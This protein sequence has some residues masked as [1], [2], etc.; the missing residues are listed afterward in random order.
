MKLS[1][2]V[3]ASSW[4]LVPRYDRLFGPSLLGS[5]SLWSPTSALLRDFGNW[6]TSMAQTSPRYEVTNTD[7]EMKLVFDVPGVIADNLDVSVDHERNVLTIS[8][9]RE[10]NENGSS[11]S[12]QFSNSFSLGPEIEVDKLNADLKDGVLTIVAPKDMKRLEANIRKIHIMSSASN[13]EPM[14]IEADKKT[15][16]QNVEVKKEAANV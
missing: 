8:G 6:D 11:F 9:R 2:P 3:V 14:K 10:S 16:A 12:Y 13:E 7:S 1:L 4:G 5:T 15:D